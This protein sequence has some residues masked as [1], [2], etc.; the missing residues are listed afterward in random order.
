M[1]SLN[2]TL[3]FPISSSFLDPNIS[4]DISPLNTFNFCSSFK[5]RKQVMGLVRPQ[6][7]DA[8]IN[9]SVILNGC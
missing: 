2:N 7:K 9:G 3:H 6:M 4:L 1:F 5:I 8:G